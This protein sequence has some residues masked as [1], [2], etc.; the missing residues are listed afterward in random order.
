MEYLIYNGKVEI[1]TDKAEA[2]EIC[3]GI[4]ADG[5]PCTLTDDKDEALALL[6]HEIVVRPGHFDG[7]DGYE[8][9]ACSVIS[10]ERGEA[11]VCSVCGYVPGEI[12]VEPS[13]III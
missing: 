12:P 8:C 3:R 13:C 9:P 1:Y 10:S 6:P 4:V 2:L 7:E 5:I 11:G